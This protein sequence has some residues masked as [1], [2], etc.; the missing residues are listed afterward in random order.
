MFKYI[1]FITI[2]G[3]LWCKTI[4][5]RGIILVGFSLHGEHGKENPNKWWSLSCKASAYRGLGDGTLVFF[6]AS[7]FLDHGCENIKPVFDFLKSGTDT[8]CKR[9][10]LSNQVKRLMLLLYKPGLSELQQSGPCPPC[11]S[12][13]RQWHA[14]AFCPPWGENE[15]SDLRTHS[16][17]NLTLHIITCNFVSHFPLGGRHCCAISLLSWWWSIYI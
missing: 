17:I 5:I 10:V 15:L 14:R 1:W 2:G 16:L 3:T 8:V 9:H 6:L 11:C 13:P 7:N 12:E 4:N